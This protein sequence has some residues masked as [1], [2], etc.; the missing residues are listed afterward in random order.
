MEDRLS[1]DLLIP[2]LKKDIIT[3]LLYIV[4][5][6]IVLYS[7]TGCTSVMTLGKPTLSDEEV[8]TLVNNEDVVREPTVDT[9]WIGDSPFT[10]KS[11]TVDSITDLESDDEK[12]AEVTVVLAN[13]SV[14]ATQRYSCSFLYSDKEWALI[15]ESLINEEVVPINGIDSDKVINQALTLIAKAD[16]GEHKYAD[17]KSCLLE[18]IYSNN[19]EFTAVK[20]NTNKNGGTIT[21]SMNSSTGFVNYRGNITAEFEWDEGIHG[22]SITECTVDDDAYLPRIDEMVGTWQGEFVSTKNVEHSNGD[23]YGAKDKP[24]KLVV[25]SADSQTGTITADLTFLAHCHYREDNPIQT[26]EGDKTITL[27]DILIP[28][29]YS[30]GSSVTAY[31]KE[32]PQRGFEFTKYEITFVYDADATIQASVRFSWGENDDG[33]SAWYTDTYVDNYKLTK[34]SAK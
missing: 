31:R 34:E 13:D 10:I 2:K 32:A 11:K 15:D 16:D 22:W 3:C 4:T 21:L 17:G 9:T 8:L 26:S 29:P 30:T 7:I 33:A 6:I 24:M 19:A 27:E 18:R 28:V 20:N 1:H 23:C 25:K 12:H 14:E 5:S